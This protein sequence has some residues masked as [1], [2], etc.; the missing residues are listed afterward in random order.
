MDI[1]R[2][3]DLVL[4]FIG[5]LTLLLGA[6]TIGRNKYILC[7]II[8]PFSA[9]CFLGFFLGWGSI[10]QKY[11]IRE[12]LM[13]RAVSLNP[14]FIFSK[15]KL[16]RNLNTLKR[17]MEE[18]I[19]KRQAVEGVRTKEELRIRIEKSKLAIEKWEEKLIE[20]NEQMELRAISADLLEGPL[21][22][23]MFIEAEKEIQEAIDESEMLLLELKAGNL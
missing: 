22:E 20:L 7:F 3:L 11:Q 15:D 12:S 14:S 2:N 5:F 17:M 13:E 9:L 6:L 23:T 19:L 18:D 10:Y 4:F 1:V 16:I 21:A 8:I